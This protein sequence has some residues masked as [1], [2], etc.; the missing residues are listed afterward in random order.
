MSY[1]GVSEKNGSLTNVPLSPTPENPDQLAEPSSA[2][3]TSPDHN[4]DETRDRYNHPPFRRY[5]LLP[6]TGKKDDAVRRQ[7]SKASSLLNRLLQRQ[8]KSESWSNGDDGVTRGR[9]RR[10]KE[11]YSLAG[12]KAEQS[13]SEEEGDED[14]GYENGQKSRPRANYSLGQPFPKNNRS[15]WAR[16]LKG[17][18][19]SKNQAA[20][21]QP[22]RNEGGTR[23]EGPS[24][25]GKPQ[26]QVR[27]IVRTSFTLKN[28]L[29]F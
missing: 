26:G 8:D 27:R 15:R 2:R 25:S 1:Q 7:P 22:K 14:L 29:R 16:N 23:V 4:P 21:G 20:E 13:E 11:D 28:L 10:R 24:D 17:K 18:G 6:G 19:G 12:P 9:S 5:S 3:V